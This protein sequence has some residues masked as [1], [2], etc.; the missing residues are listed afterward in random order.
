MEAQDFDYSL[1]IHLGIVKLFGE[2]YNNTNE[3]VIDGQ[4]MNRNDIGT[5]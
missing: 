1:H 4:K 5:F 2:Y 3:L